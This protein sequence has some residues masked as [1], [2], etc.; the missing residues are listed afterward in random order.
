MPLVFLADEPADLV[1]R[2]ERAVLRCHC[3]LLRSSASL[4]PASERKLQRE[5]NNARVAI[6]VGDLAEGGVGQ[7]GIGILE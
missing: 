7:V 5:L 1:A 3:F 4:L 2:D 6:S